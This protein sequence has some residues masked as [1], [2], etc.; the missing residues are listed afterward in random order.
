MAS[1]V[2]GISY[3]PPTGAISTLFQLITLSWS[4]PTGFVVCLR[5]AFP[6]YSGTYVHQHPPITP[7]R[8]VRGV[9]GKSPMHLVSL[10]ATACPL[11][12]LD[13]APCIALEGIVKPINAQVLQSLSRGQYP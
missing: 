1:K 7:K 4:T 9:N 12:S 3:V 13:L 6:L 10:A 5:L 8:K 2:A 11:A